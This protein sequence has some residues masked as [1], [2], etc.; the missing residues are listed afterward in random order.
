M[1]ATGAQPNGR[2]KRSQA[3]IE[4]DADE[5]HGARPPATTLPVA[6]AVASIAEMTTMYAD[7]RRS[8]A[9]GLG[10]ASDR[11]EDA[12][13]ERRHHGDDDHDRDRERATPRA[14]SSRSR[15][16]S[17]RAPTRNAA[18]PGTKRSCGS[19]SSTSPA[20]ENTSAATNHAAPRAARRP[21][22]RAAPR[23]DQRRRAS[24]ACTRT[25]ARDACVR[26]RLARSSP[27]P[28]TPPATTNATAVAAFTARAVRA[29]QPPP[30]DAP[31]AHPVV[32]PVGPA[33]P[34][35]ELVDAHHEAAP[36][37]RQRRLGVGEPRLDLGDACVEQLA[38]LDDRAL[39][40]RPRAQAMTARPAVP[41]ARRPRRRRP[42]APGRRRAPAA[43]APASG[44]RARPA[45]FAASSAALGALEVREEREAALV[46]TP[47]QHRARRHRAVGRRGRQRHRV[48]LAHPGR[49]RLVVPAPELGD[50]I[51]IDGVGIEESGVRRHRSAP[52]GARMERMAF[53]HVA[54]ATRDLDATHRFYSEAM[55]FE[56][57]RVE[58]HAVHGERA[59]PATCSTTPATARCSR[60]GTCTTRTCPTSIPRSR[61]GSGC[62]A[63]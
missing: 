32:Q 23:R 43:P 40:R 50:R 19:I 20:S 57:V 61:P 53:H 13:P 42:V 29:R 5:E 58:A 45:G 48:G 11:R 41:V 46:E 4:S 60:S 9:R 15:R 51:G 6:S 34:A 55:G 62:R 3:I 49:D 39:R 22:G 24:R 38:R 33:L 59:G 16:G 26:S 2:T 36:E 56:L 17:R 21:P 10:A 28:R 18:S 44:T 14:R 52:I 12:P 1:I 35:L 27:R 54:I 8:A 47:Q 30:V 7:D 63:S 25:R 31:V 37:R